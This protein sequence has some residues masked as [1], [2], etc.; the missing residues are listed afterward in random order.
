M[1]VLLAAVL[2]HPAARMSLLLISQIQ[3]VMLNIKGQ[4]TANGG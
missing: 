4:A 1:L 2:I 3:C